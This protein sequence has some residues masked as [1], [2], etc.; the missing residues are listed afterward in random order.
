MEKLQAAFDID[1]GRKFGPGRGGIDMKMLPCINYL[2][3]I[4]YII[5][6]GLCHPKAAKK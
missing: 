2:Q 5:E 1:C 4:A 3:F 6:Q